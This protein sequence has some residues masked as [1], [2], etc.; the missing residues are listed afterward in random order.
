MKLHLDDWVCVLEYVILVSIGIAVFNVL[1][2][3]S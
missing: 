3:C 1:V 2:K